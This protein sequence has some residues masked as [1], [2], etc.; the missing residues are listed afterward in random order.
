M[1]AHCIHNDNECTYEELLMKD[2]SVSIHHRNLQFLATE[3]FKVYK[4]QGP[5]ILQDVFPL[6]PQATYNLRNQP[7]FAS[8]TIRTVHYGENSLRHLGPKLWEMI[9]SSIKDTESVETFKNKIK[10]WIPDIC[11]CRLCKTYIH[12]VGFI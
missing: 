4:K 11:P 2:N 7:H 3:M 5:D 8:R 9:P 6:N 10:S 12:Q 1:F